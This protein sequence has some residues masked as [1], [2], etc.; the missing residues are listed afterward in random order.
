MFRCKRSHGSLRAPPFRLEA[1]NPARPRANRPINRSGLALRPRRYDPDH[2]RPQIGAFPRRS[3]RLTA[4]QRDREWRLTVKSRRRHVSSIVPGTRE[5]DGPPRRRARPSMLRGLSESGTD[6]TQKRFAN[7]RAGS[8]RFRGRRCR[9]DELASEQLSLTAPPTTSGLPT[10]EQ[11]SRELTHRSP[12]AAQ[13]RGVRVDAVESSV[14]QSCPATRAYL[15]QHAFDRLKRGGRPRS[16][17]LTVGSSISQPRS[18]ET[19]PRHE[20]AGLRFTCGRGHV[21]AETFRLSHRAA[22]PIHFG[23][24][25]RNPPVHRALPGAS[26]PRPWADVALPCAYCSSRQRPADSPKADIP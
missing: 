23:S 5:V 8:L 25:T 15:D 18:I 6:S 22:R 2:P 3:D 11:L 19:A 1:S 21:S 7:A 20:H 12:R 13:T 16:A 14:V 26:L 9:V 24:V 17:T 10:G 4:V